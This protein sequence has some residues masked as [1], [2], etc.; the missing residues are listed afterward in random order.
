MRKVAEWARKLIGERAIPLFTGPL[1]VIYHHRIPAPLSKRQWRRNE[2]HLLPCWARPDEDNL[3][4][5]INDALNGIVWKDDSQICF[6]VRTKSITSAKVGE[7]F[8]HV[9]PLSPTE[10]FDYGAILDTITK[11]LT[12][13]GHDDTETRLLR[14]CDPRH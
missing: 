2:Y 13:D 5:F 3:G 12:V 4:K 14:V 8:L 7:T 10:A 9:R 1:L 6:V 11:N